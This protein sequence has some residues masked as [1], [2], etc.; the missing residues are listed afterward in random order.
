M[1]V[2]YDY[3]QVWAAHPWVRVY[4][5]VVALVLVLAVVGTVIRGP[6]A[7][8]FIPALLGAYMHHIMAMR[9]LN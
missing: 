4:A 1:D 7:I 9:R 2:W 6:L 8:L 3:R 5:L